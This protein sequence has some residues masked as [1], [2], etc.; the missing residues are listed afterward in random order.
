MH[1][2][3]KK[4]V[5]KLK[6]TFKETLKLMKGFQPMPQLDRPMYSP[7]PP[8]EYSSDYQGGFSS[9]PYQSP[10]NVP[11]MDISPWFQ[12]GQNDTPSTPTPHN[13][14]KLLKCDESYSKYSTS[15][16]KT[17]N[18]DSEAESTDSDDR[19][20]RSP[21]KQRN[22]TTAKKGKLKKCCLK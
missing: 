8:L 21:F 9:E 22:T 15:S 11:R 1:F 10:M 2:V 7:I 16:S 3:V 6:T 12:L 17:L 13:S 14:E 20:S 5:T 4:D 18:D 19:W